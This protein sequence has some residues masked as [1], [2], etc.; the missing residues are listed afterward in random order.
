MILMK[1]VFDIITNENAWKRRNELEISF[2]I[3]V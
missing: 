2:D 3:T 1:Q